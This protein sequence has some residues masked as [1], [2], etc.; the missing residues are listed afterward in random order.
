MAF[1]TVTEEALAI[2]RERVA[3]SGIARPVVR[4]D[5][6]EIVG[7]PPDADVDDKEWTNKRKELWRLEVAA[8]DGIADGDSRIAE[9]AGLRFVSDFFP[10]RFDITVKDGK[11]RVAASAA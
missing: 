7:A 8:G 3:A 11:L 10:I 9:A 1:V 4:I 6:G 2:L 5:M